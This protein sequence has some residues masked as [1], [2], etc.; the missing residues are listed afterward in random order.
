[1]IRQLAAAYESHATSLPWIRVHGG[2]YDSV[3]DDPRFQDL[4]RK[5]KLP[6]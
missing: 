4:L 6:L 3:R 1:M 2:L 5:M